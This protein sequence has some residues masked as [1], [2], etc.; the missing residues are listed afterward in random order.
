MSNPPSKPPTFEEALAQL[1]AIVREMEEGEIGLDVSLE[2]YEQGIALIK[3]CHAQLQAA[4]Q[5]IEM[6]MDVDEEGQPVLKPFQHQATAPTKKKTTKKKQSPNDD[7]E[8]LP[9]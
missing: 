8:G 2:K 3:Q 7:N 9:F 4:E 1:E 5:R 6:L